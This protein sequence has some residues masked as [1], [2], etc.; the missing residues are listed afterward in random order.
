MISVVTITYNNFEELI[1]TLDS[2]PNNNLIQSVVINGGKCQKTKIF[3]E[4]YH[5]LSISEP[6]R[7]IS[8]AFNKGIDLSSGDYIVFLN[9]G[10][11]LID[12][13]YFLKSHDILSQHLDLGFVYSSIEF[14]HPI[15]GKHIYYPSSPSKGD[16]PY[17]HPS[18]I[19]RR[20]I[21]SIIGTF[22][23][24]YNM[25][26]DYEFAYRLIKNGYKGLYYKDGPVV[27]MDGNG[28]SSNSTLSGLKERTKAL[29][30]NGAFSLKIGIIFSIIRFKYYTRKILALVGL[31]PLYDS[32]RG[33]R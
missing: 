28:V 16:M 11:L 24:D 29:K 1:S 9:S 8:N 33:R 19:V 10:D 4:S 31:L 32:L 27:H 15:F 30:D 14:N 20:D 17:P 3:L 21:F 7:G 13:E 18:L 6:D 2:I 5:G 23:E 25:A 12:S 22:S 26:M